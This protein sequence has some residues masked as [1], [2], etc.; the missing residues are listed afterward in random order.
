MAICTG[1]L[2]VATWQQTLL[3]TLFELCPFTKDWAT[4]VYIVDDD[5]HRCI[6][7]FYSPGVLRQLQSLLL[8][9]DG[10]LAQW[11]QSYVHVCPF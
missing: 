1:A 3:I 4:I 10:H 8:H 9:V 5:H 11:A 6:F 7:F 2:H